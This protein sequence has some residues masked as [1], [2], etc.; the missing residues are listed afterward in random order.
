[1]RLR[2]IISRLFGAGKKQSKPRPIP[3]RKPRAFLGEG[4]F[5]IPK[6]SAAYAEILASE[7]KGYT[8]EKLQQELA[9]IKPRMPWE[10]WD[11]F[12]NN[13]YRHKFNRIQTSFIGFRL[14]KGGLCDI[15]P[16]SQLAKIKPT[17]SG[18]K[19]QEITNE[20]MRF[21]EPA[22]RP[23]ER[24]DLIFVRGKLLN[25][26]QQLRL[27]NDGIFPLKPA[28]EAILREHGLL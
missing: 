13:E 12:E 26:V 11:I 14:K 20:F 1:M 21:V 23:E 27:W 25:A 24:H 10:F 2:K 8:P 22:G 9:V 18:M 15:Y 5:A 7:R 3:E 17:R 6:E 28:Y 16:L 4:F 19:R